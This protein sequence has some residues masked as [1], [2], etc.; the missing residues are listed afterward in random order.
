MKIKITTIREIK[1][2]DF[3]DYIDALNRYT[4]CH[5][6]GDR[7]LAGDKLT[8]SIDDR[9]VKSTITYEIVKE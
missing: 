8:D 6:A 5:I 2:E 1:D 7:L 4:H 3:N 9:H